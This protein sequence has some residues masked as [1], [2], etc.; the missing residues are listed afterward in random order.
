[1]ATEASRDVGRRL[2][3]LDVLL[4]ALLYLIAY[5]IQAA[6]SPYGPANP[7]AHYFLLPFIIAVFVWAMS[8]A[9]AYRFFR[10]SFLTHAGMVASSLAFS[11]GA[12]LTILYLFKEGWMSRIVIVWFSLSVLIVLTAIRSFFI[13]WYFSRASSAVA[14]QPK[15]LIVGSGQR[16]KRVS[17]ALAHHSEW[18]ADIIGYLDNRSSSQNTNQVADDKILGTINDINKILKNNVVDEVVVAVPRSMIGQVSKIFKACEEEGVKLRL[19]AD[20]YDFNI[21]R[22]QLDLMGET[23]LLSFEPVA[24][25]AN[26]LL[27]KRLFDIIAVL[28]AMPILLPVTIIAAIAVKIDSPGPAFFIQKRVGYRK[29][30]FPMFKFRS[31]YVDAE[32]R[33]KDIEHLNEADGPIF[34]ITN[35]PRVTRMGKWIRKTSIDELPQLFNVLLGHMSL[36]GPRPMS[37]RDVD[38]FD[39]SV[40]RKRFSVMPGLTCLWQISGRSNLPFDKWL[41]LDLTYID[42]WSFKLDLEILFKTIPVILKGEGAV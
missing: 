22:M 39:N 35:D 13:W 16:A 26:E 24:Q 41:E 37:I 5:R 8:Y 6:F 3:T 36:V 30:I 17:E 21:A 15:I 31:M 32:A 42:H 27:L 1:M 12:L 14:R 28:M 38:L 11:I 33:L 40:Q 34:K 25:N 20:I 9:G 29:R 2:C 7:E 10:V 4:V 18:G 23:P 19:M